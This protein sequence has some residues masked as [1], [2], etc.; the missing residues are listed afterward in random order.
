MG[1]SDHYIYHIYICSFT[2]RYIWQRDF[3]WPPGASK[4]SLGVVVSEHLRPT[5]PGPRMV[6]DPGDRGRIGEIPSFILGVGLRLGSLRRKLARFR[7]KVRLE[8]R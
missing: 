4:V 8:V 3:T 5:V 1:F 2:C 7:D 6:P